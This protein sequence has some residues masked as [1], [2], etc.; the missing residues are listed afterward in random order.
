M[1]S[2]ERGSNHPISKAILEEAE[3]DNIKSIKITASIK[4]FPGK[5]VEG[6]EVIVGNLDFLKEH[7]IDIDVD[8]SEED[9]FSILD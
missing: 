1:V 3:K 6:K 4:P 9:S 8:L 7:R 5:G 2:I